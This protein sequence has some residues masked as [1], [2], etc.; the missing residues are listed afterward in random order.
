LGGETD[1]VRVFLIVCR[2][3]GGLIALR[4]VGTVAVEL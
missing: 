4:G 2:D 3:G 1:R